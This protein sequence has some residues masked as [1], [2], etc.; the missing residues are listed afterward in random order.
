MSEPPVVP[1]AV[2][3]AAQR[4]SSDGGRPSLRESPP[5][6]EE[7]LD[8]HDLPEAVRPATRKRQPTIIDVAETAGVAIGTVS[9]HLNGLS[10]RRGNRD[11]IERAIE[12]LGYHRN[13]VAAAMKTDLTQVI[14]LMVPTFDEF[15]GVMLEYLAHSIRRTG[16]ALLTYCHG[17]DPRI[18]QESLD[19]FATQRIDALIM[20]GE[21]ALYHGVDELIQRGTPVIFY[22]NDLK[23]LPADRVFVDNQRAS[24]RA[25]SHLLDL[26]H[27]RIAII[28]G[29]HHDSS[30][31]E[32]FEG[33]ALALGERG[34]AFDERYVVQGGWSVDGG[35]HGL[36]T[37]MAL[38]DPPTAVF[39]S[40]YP[41]AVGALAWLKDRGMKVP[42]DLSLVSFD[43][44]PL[45]RLHE[46]GITAIA[47]PVAKIADSLTSLLVSRLSHGADERPRTLTLDCDIILRGSTRR[48]V[49]T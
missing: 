43:D 45:F 4:S 19:F 35:Y 14:G 48:L 23:G 44:V 15:H 16:R 40:S 30:G 8:L 42:D 10:V 11:Q 2:G 38:D 13:A 36:A 12:T 25:V 28:D 47:Q 6:V 18:M 3:R 29:L 17:A 9:R 1:K 39:A 22:N 34:V 24:K 41:M 27:R 32:R 20:T 21:E 31:L 46:M 49:E 26:G 7:R 37:L 5:Q 33:Y